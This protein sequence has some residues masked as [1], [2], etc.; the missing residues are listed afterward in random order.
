MTFVYLAN[1]SIQRDLQARR[2]QSKEPMEGKAA[3]TVN[4]F[5]FTCKKHQAAERRRLEVQ[6]K[7][8]EESDSAVTELDG[9]EFDFDFD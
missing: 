8:P 9:K 4:S 1:T 6:W 7:Q 5:S 3:N 2:N